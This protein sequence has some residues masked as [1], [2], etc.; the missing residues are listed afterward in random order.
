M[1]PLGAAAA[2]PPACPGAG[3]EGVAAAWPPR[4][5]SRYLAPAV[6]LVT[7]WTEAMLDGRG[8]SE[9]PPPAAPA[10]AP[11]SPKAAKE[12]P[13]VAEPCCCAT[14]SRERITTGQLHDLS[15]GQGSKSEGRAARAREEQQGYG[16][17]CGVPTFR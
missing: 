8:A 4:L 11:S 9:A 15:A 10:A 14:A 13:L 7:E 12:P 16:P 2:L 17:M 1:T 3:A 6:L 5:R